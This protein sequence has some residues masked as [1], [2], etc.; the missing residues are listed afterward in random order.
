MRR[1]LL[2]CGLALAVM[3]AVTTSADAA[4]LASTREVKLPDG[5]VRMKAYSCS[6]RSSSTGS[7][8][9]LGAA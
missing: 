2:A 5:S 3:T 1:F 9:Q 8:K 6:L 7:A 4:C